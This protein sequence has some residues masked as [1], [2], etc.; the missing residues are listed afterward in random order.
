MIWGNSSRWMPFRVFKAMKYF[1]SLKAMKRRG[2]SQ[3]YA[4]VPFESWVRQ[5]TADYLRSFRGDPRQRKGHAY[6]KGAH[7]WCAGVRRSPKHTISTSTS[8]NG[9][10]GSVVSVFNKSGFDSRGACE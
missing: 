6:S 9:P 2:V 10:N 1:T 3:C 4:T 7:E 5:E 8:G